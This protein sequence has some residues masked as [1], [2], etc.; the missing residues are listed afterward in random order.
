MINTKYIGKI[1]E[2]INMSVAERIPTYHEPATLPI[3]RSTTA[4]HP[5]Q[6]VALGIILLLSGVLNFWA[7]DQM[8]YSNT[9]YAA[10]VKSM[11]QSWHNFFFVSFDAAGFVSVDKP[12]L[13]LWLQAASAK[14]FGFSGVSLILPQA[15]AGL[16]SVALLY[17]LVRRIFGPGTG[18][19]S[20]LAL[21]ITP[22]S[23]VVSRNNIV[24]ST[25]ILTLLLGTWAVSCGVETGRLRWLLLC[26]LFI[27][28][29]FNIKMMQAYLVIPAFGLMYL[30]G[31]SL[32]WRKRILHLFLASILLLTVSLSWAVAVDLT[33]ASQRPYVG[34]TQ[35]NSELSLAFGYNGIE[36]LLG[37][38]F[39]GQHSSNTN[40][41][42]PASSNTTNTSSTSTT[43]TSSTS[44]TSTQQR[45]S[46]MPPRGGNGGS[47]GMFNTGQAGILRLFNE[48]LG[49]QAS[50]LL[51][52]A[53]IGMVVAA[54]QE[55][56]RLP[57]TR[58]QQ[59]VVLWGTWLLTMGVF[60][61][62]AGFFHQY[63]LATIAPAIAALAGIGIMALW[64]EYRGGGWRSWL[65]PV[66]LMVT[67][68]AQIYMLSSYQTW[69]AIL[70]P[71]VAGLCTVG[72][73]GL[74]LAL[75]IPRL[76]LMQRLQ[77]TAVI[78]A[79]IS[80][81]IT[82]AVWTG[83]TV[84]QHNGG[85][86]PS[87]GPSTMSSFGGGGM[88]GGTEQVDQK[89]VQYLLAHQGN[90]TYLFATTNAT[91]AAPYIIST[92]KAVM[93]MGG[94]A[95]SDNILTTQQ[96]AALVKSGKV[97]YFLISSS[98]NG[99]GGSSSLTSWIQQHG[100]VVPTSQWQSSS[101]ASAGQSGP[102]GSLTL[103][104]Y[105]MEHPEF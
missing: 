77:R 81:L 23:V 78:L 3:K 98:G 6:K 75:V 12:P 102:G 90:A 79:V 28:L 96:L 103:Y 10:A 47:G 4:S 2:K 51:P 53:L 74:I 88:G 24:D 100:T 105:N 40:Q 7:L 91:A 27:G 84:L 101:T 61:S 104:V 14:I 89:L 16:L 97:R 34:S 18:L 50:W 17:Y 37:M 54:S 26:A 87:A 38:G 11:L 15:I 44:S 70:S 21:A 80:L 60:F 5:W 99:P 41:Q 33:P 1:L 48:G 42:P 85:L 95:G 36:R 35:D 68:G 13:D 30:L 66:A 32:S 64:R 46:G 55:K 39:G 65:L 76:R 63:Y 92:G 31:S 9:Y 62:V 22:V 20:A 56:V 73:L 49:G 82:P 58:K 25:L 59:A 94:F 69:S 71:V 52:L 72:A 57:L 43:N 8:G 29:G 19:L 93:A 83:I 45:P 67:A 86:T